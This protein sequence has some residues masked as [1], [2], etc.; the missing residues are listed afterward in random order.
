MTT[1]TISTHT[2]SAVRLGMSMAD[3]VRTSSQCSLLPTTVQQKSVW[4]AVATVMRDESVRTDAAAIAG[5]DAG[6]FPGTSAWSPPT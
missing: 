6:T 1:N 5:A 3:R 4:G 2:A